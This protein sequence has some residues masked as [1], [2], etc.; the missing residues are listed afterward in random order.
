MDSTVYRPVLC[1]NGR[2]SDNVA[3]QP[4]ACDR[5]LGGVMFVQIISQTRPP[6]PNASGLPSSGIS[7]GKLPESSTRPSDHIN[8][9]VTSGSIRA[10]VSPVMVAI[11]ILLF[12]AG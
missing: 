8:N 11:A 4:Q 12:M 6:V 10:I 7:S 5:C 2:P 1:T 9:V 3:Y